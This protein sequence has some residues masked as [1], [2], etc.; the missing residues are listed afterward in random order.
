MASSEVPPPPG[1]AKA[2]PP[3]PG[4]APAEERPAE[5]GEEWIE[6]YESEKKVKEPRK[7]VPHLFGMIAVVA[8]ILIL[9][10]WTLISP[11]VLPEAGSDYL[12]PSPYANLG[13]YAGDLDIWW[14]FNAVH[15]ANTTWGVSV[16]GDPNVTAGQAATFQVLVTKVHEE[17]KNAWFVGTSLSL[18]HVT[19]MVEGGPQVG[20]MVSKS[21]Q[22][23]GP[24]AEVEAT[25]DEPGNYS[26]SVYVEVTVY[27]KMLIGYLPVKVLR[28]TADLDVAIVAS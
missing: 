28:I 3:P 23:Y 17:V 6:E 10:V 22:T 7:K 16:S 13:S 19:L 2:S 18:K 8:V 4:P 9:V 11:Q 12:A 21:S 27:G 20:E 25:F 15:V 14:L 26:C 24:I 1:D 5:P